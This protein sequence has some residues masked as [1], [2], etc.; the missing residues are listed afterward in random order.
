QLYEPILISYLGNKKDYVYYKD[1]QVFTE[2][3]SIFDDLQSSFISE[4]VSNAVSVP[5]IFT[6]STKTQVIAYGNIDSVQINNKTLLAKLIENMSNENK[7]IEIELQEGQ[8]NYIF[9]RDSWI[10]TQL[11][12]YPF[13]QF[14]VMGIFILIAYFLFS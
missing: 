12:Y 7:P 14:G 11:K 4:V 6:D 10:L 2:L 8:F 3:Q 9:Y 1:S 5:V 13:I